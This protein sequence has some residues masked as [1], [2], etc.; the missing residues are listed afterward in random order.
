MG[1][2]TIWYVYL[3]YKITD[4]RDIYE[5]LLVYLR[6][7]PLWYA[8]IIINWM[9]RAG[10]NRVTHKKEKEL[11]IRKQ[12]GFRTDTIKKKKQENREHS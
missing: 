8:A 5:L 1:I 11:K 3:I 12:P 9:G 7:W 2:I 6:R 10:R 4:G